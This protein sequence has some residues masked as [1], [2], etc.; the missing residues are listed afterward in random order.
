MNEDCNS[1]R[2]ELLRQQIQNTN[3]MKQKTIE[4]I[5]ENLLIM[6]QTKNKDRLSSANQ[7]IESLLEALFGIKN[8]TISIVK[9]LKSLQ[10]PIKKYWKTE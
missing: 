2:I 9:E 4:K 3:E 1:K 6:S 7:K 10:N 5:N 8:M